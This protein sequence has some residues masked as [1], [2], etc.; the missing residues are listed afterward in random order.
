LFFSKNKQKNIFE[1]NNVV[2]GEHATKEY[3]K[4]VVV[5]ENIHKKQHIFYIF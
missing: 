2:F 1:K 3:I 5:G 4:S